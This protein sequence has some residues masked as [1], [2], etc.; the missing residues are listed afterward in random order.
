MRMHVDENDYDNNDSENGF[1]EYQISVKYKNM[2]WTRECSNK[3]KSE[4]KRKV[5][6]T[7]L[8]DLSSS[9]M[10]VKVCLKQL[11]DNH[12]SR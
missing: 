2:F 5:Q 9:L 6:T 8:F 10:S 3:I 12:L 11:S 4:Y 7:Y 1:R